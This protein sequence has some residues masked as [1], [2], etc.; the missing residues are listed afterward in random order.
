MMSVHWSDLWEESSPISRI[1]SDMLLPLSWLYALGWKGYLAL[2]QM[3]WKKRWE[4]PIPVIG[5][6]SLE[7][8]GSGKTPLALAVA[9]I[10]ETRFKKIAISVHG[11]KGSR[12]NEV[13]F[14]P[15]GMPFS[16]EEFGDEAVWLREKAPQ[17]ALVVSRHRVLAVKRSV[18]EGCDAVVLDD[19]FQH[20]P[21]ARKVDFVILQPSRRN[22]RCLPAG[23]L[24]EPWKGWQRADAVFVYGPPIPE[25]PLPQFRIQRIFS[26]LHALNTS[27]SLPVEWLRGKEISAMCAIGKPHTFLQALKD[28]GANVREFL[29]LPDHSSP[30]ALPQGRPLIVTEK[31]AVKLL[32]RKLPLNDVY[33]LEMDLRVDDEFASWLRER[34]GN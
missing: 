18:Q 15:P 5:V 7:V 13:T 17:F 27:E 10:L 20:L 24:R 28:L 25:I 19:G 12:R 21:L 33:A 6:G 26:R 11:Y 32:H 22:R 14:L 2:Y 29:A 8:G 23:P 34:L 30:R 3:G 1:L 9:R 4:A 31:D 16:E